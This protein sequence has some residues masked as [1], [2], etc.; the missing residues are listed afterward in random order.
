M[1]IV[2]KLKQAVWKKMA[3]IGGLIFCKNILIENQFWQQREAEGKKN[4]SS[5]PKRKVY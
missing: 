4:L 2:L 3:A 5:S 1:Y